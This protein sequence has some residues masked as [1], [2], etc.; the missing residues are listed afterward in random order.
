MCDSGPEWQVSR[1]NLHGLVQLS[2][3]KTSLDN[4]R[5]PPLCQGHQSYNDNSNSVKRQ[6]SQEPPF[7]QG[8]VQGPPLSKSKT[9]LVPSPTFHATI[10]PDSGISTFLPPPTA[11]V[12][13]LKRPLKD[14]DQEINLN[15]H[16]HGPPTMNLQSLGIIA[17]SNNLDK[18]KP[19][20]KK[21][22]KTSERSSQFE[23]DE[24]DTLVDPNL[25]PRSRAMEFVPLQVGMV[26]EQNKDYGTS[27]SYKDRNKLAS[28]VHV[29]NIGQNKRLANDS[30]SKAVSDRR[31]LLIIRLIQIFPDYALRVSELGQPQR[32]HFKPPPILDTIHVFVD[33]SN[34]LFG[35]HESVQGKGDHPPNAKANDIDMSFANFALIIERGR[36]AAKRVLAGSDHLPA[37]KDAENLGYEVNILNRVR[38]GRYQI[39]PEIASSGQRW[40]EQGVDEILH[41]K[42]LES[43]LDSEEPATMVL[44]SGDAAKAEYSDGFLT[45]LKR[46]L[47]RG[48]NVELV[49]FRKALGSA[50]KNK[51]FRAMWRPRFEILLLDEF[52]HSLYEGYLPTANL[53]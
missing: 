18:K 40:V 52:V 39:K 8:S 35:L 17:P 6:T 9:A 4:I 14:M 21:E 27:T 11:T 47:Q 33:M 12:T 51:D 41:L 30:N 13:L 43:I 50:Y 24:S 28:S 36:L 20:S 48:W 5:S 22:Q 10:A 31:L 32:C 19:T 16:M 42:M 49:S 26:G 15:A 3:K 2:K 1:S 7:T 53:Y 44:A 46:A 25:L 37:T 38:K 23:S 34:I 29:E 45:M